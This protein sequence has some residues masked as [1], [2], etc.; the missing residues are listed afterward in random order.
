MELRHSL[1]SA[2][3]SLLL[4]RV[5]TTVRDLLQRVDPAGLGHDAH[6]FWSVA[7]AAAAATLAET[8]APPPTV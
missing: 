6:L 2:E 7:D 3:K 8:P 4:A 1:Q 5:K